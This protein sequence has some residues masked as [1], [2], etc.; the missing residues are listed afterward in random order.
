MASVLAGFALFVGLRHR[1]AAQLPDDDFDGPVP[2]DRGRAGADADV[3][4]RPPRRTAR[5]VPGAAR[6]VGAVAGPGR[7]ASPRSTSAPLGGG[8]RPRWHEARGGDPLAGRR[9]R[10]D[11]LPD[12]PDEQELDRDVAARLARLGAEVVV[13]DG[14]PRYHL[15]ECLHLLGRTAHRLPV[16]EAVELGFTPCGECEPATA[17]LFASTG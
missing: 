8:R 9:R 2:S 15:G 4:R 3:R 16:M 6:R 13:I 17:L 11:A 5:A 14:R 12:E 1:P 10:R 7:P